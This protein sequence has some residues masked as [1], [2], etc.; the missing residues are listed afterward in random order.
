VEAIA[1]VSEVGRDRYGAVRGRREPLRRAGRLWRP[2]HPGRIPD[3]SKPLANPLKSCVSCVLLNVE[4]E[5]CQGFATCLRKWGSGGRWFESSRPDIEG[6]LS[7][8]DSQP[9]LLLP[10]DLTATLFSWSVGPLSP[11]VLSANDSVCTS[12][13][14]L[15]ANWCKLSRLVLRPGCPSGFTRSLISVEGQRRQGVEGSPHV[16]QGGVG[17]D[18]HRQLDVGVSHR[19]LCRPRR[20]PTFA[21]QRPEG[22]PQSV[23]V[24]GAA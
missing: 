14:L 17:V 13:H 19:R 3:L 18:V 12:L 9:L 22:V 5:E 16:Q 1:G 4:E 20:H 7:G 10:H 2:L 24:E 21:E 8:D 6:R 15:G 11:S 23:N